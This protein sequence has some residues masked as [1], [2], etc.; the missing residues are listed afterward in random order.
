ML[1]LLRHADAEDANGRPDA[2]R[3]LTEKGRAQARSVG[4]ALK[5]D[6]PV[7]YAPQAGLARTLARI[8]ELTRDAAPAH[9]APHAARAL[10][11][12]RRRYGVTQWLTAAVIAQAIGLGVLGSAYLARPAGDRADAR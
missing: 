3:P 12:P 8:D 9:G 11:P 5:A 2:E 7:E 10:Q 4:A 1:W 6:G